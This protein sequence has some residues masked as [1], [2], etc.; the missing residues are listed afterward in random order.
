[1]TSKDGKTVVKE[2]IYLL[3]SSQE[4]TDTRVIL[5]AAYGCSEGYANIRVKSPDSDIFFIML[6]HAASIQSVLF[7]DTGT[8]NNKRLI[9]VSKIAKGYGET[10]CTSLMVLHAFSGCDS[11]S[12]F[13]GI[14]KVKPIKILE[15]KKNFID[16]F[17]AVGDSWN[18][19]TNIL[20]S[21]EEFTCCLYG[22]PRFS[23][24][25]SLRYH[26]LKKKCVDSDKIDPKKTI[27]LSAFPP[28]QNTFEQH[29]KR[30]M[31]QVGIWKRAIEQ[32]PEVVNPDGIGW[33]KNEGVLEP[34]WCEGPVLQ[35]CLADPV[36]N[37]CEDELDLLQEELDSD[38]E[39]T[40][41]EN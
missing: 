12:A 2:E 29:V 5:Y 17:A 22:Y 11:T 19:S 34:L 16:S 26:C 39:D 35:T 23:S 18:V 6:H 40:D 1:M 41:V 31:Y 33:V 24:L 13:K 4:E 3:R 15:K 38:S 37:D 8:G 14:G 10:Y 9:D 28:C 21:L 20:Q 36:E 7:F 27:D 32:F 30:T 25:D